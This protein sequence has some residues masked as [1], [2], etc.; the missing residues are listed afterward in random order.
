MAGKKL[1]QGNILVMSEDISSKEDVV[2]LLDSDGDTIKGYNLFKNEVIDIDRKE[3]F[4]N[5]K[6]NNWWLR[7]AYD[8]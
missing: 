7:V 6:K 2:I 3:I 5:L 8:L 4:N 1:K